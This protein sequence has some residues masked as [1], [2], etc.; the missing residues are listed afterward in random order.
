MKTKELLDHDTNYRW[1][2]AINKFHEGKIGKGD[3]QHWM[4]KAKRA[5]YELPR[6]TRLFGM[7]RTGTLPEFHKQCSYSKAVPIDN[8]LQCCL[9]VKCAECKE[10]LALDEADM[11]DER[12]DLAK[13]WTCIAHILTIPY[14]QVDTSEGY[15]LTVSDRMYWQNV[16]ESMSDKEEE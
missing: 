2:R 4:Y 15:I 14:T 6:L 12:K 1:H 7:E 9:G 11:S 13:A 16:Y 5:A 3:W 8:Y 10:L